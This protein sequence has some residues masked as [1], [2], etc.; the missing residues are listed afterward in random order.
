MRVSRVSSLN[1]VW[2]FC[3]PSSAAA[4]VLLLCWVCFSDQREGCSLGEGAGG[5]VQVLRVCSQAGARMWH[6]TRG[7]PS[8]DLRARV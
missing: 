1:L 5:C 7:C 6:D 3:V 4:A 2:V 8:Q